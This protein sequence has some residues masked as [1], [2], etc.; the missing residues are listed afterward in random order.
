MH[1]SKR[2][3]LILAAL[4]AAAM[5]AA[6]ILPATAPAQQDDGQNIQANLENVLLEDFIRFISKYTGKNIVYRPDEIPEVEFNIQ[7]YTPFSDPELMAIFRHVLLNAGLVAVSKGEAMYVYPASKARQIPAR[8]SGAGRSGDGQEVVTT[9]Y[10]LPPGLSIKSAQAALQ[11]LTSQVG[12][13]TPIPE[14]DAVIISDQRERMDAI[15]DILASLGSMSGDWDFEIIPLKAAAAKNVAAL[16]NNMFEEVRKRG[17]AVK[18]PLISP[19]EWNNSILVT[20]TPDQREKVREFLAELDHVDV[21][22]EGNIRVYRLQ[23]AEAVPVADVLQSLME[24]KLERQKE[25]EQAKKVTDMDIFKVS[26]DENTNSIIVLTGKDMFPQ[27]E[28]IIDQLDQPQD[29]VYCEVLVM[30]TSLANARRFGVEWIAGAGDDTNIGQFG[31]I[32][33][34]TG[35]S[36]LFGYATPALDGGRPGFE[37]LPGGFSLGVLGNM[38]T[39]QGES[40]PTIN[41]LIDYTKSIDEMNILST[42]QLMTLDHAPAEI[43]VG[44]NRPFLISEK[45][46]ANNNPVQTFDYRDVGI[47]LQI[48]PH[49]NKKEGLIRLD[50]YQEVKD[51]A[52]TTQQISQPIT[53]TRYT[54][55]SVQIMDGATIVIS[56]LIQDDSTRGKTGMP[57]LASIP[58]LG[59]LFKRETASYDK[60]TLMVFLSSRIIHTLERARE[61]TRAKE[62]KIEDQME[63]TRKMYD[64]E[65]EWG[66]EDVESE[67]LREEAPGE[68]SEE[69]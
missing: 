65:F 47:K 55:T 26:A 27:I 17:D 33:R 67:R 53:L 7:T 23:N 30:E 54:R 68:A 6:A 38:V 16:V 62:K 9:V 2:A 56:G 18:T 59:W 69:P 48:T 14:A 13:V 4:F 12:S 19:I 36:D 45:F 29:Q 66:G 10:R 52:A 31:F 25:E 64:R 50:L 5:L 60:R 43:F 42:P 28:S 51:V 15:M 24:A 58:V 49:I 41:A 63:K 44:E 3:P 1:H 37:S 20:G 22:E 46:D 11:G 32:D 35:A 40:F 34:S 39:Y 57:G 21:E 61:L 8:V